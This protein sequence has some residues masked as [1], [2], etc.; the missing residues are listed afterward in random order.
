[1]QNLKLHSDSELS[2]QVFNTEYF[3][4]ERHNQPFLMA[5]INEEFHYTDD[6]MDELITDLD[7]DLEEA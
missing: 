1:M 7:D 3:Y 2:L 5:L 6:Q 4:I